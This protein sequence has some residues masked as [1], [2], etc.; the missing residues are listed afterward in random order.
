MNNKKTIL[1]A[2]LLA[3]GMCSFKVQA[4]DAPIPPALP[5]ITPA[6]SPNQATL[7]ADINFRSPL[8]SSQKNNIFQIYFRLENNFSKSEAGI[9]YGVQLVK[10]NK[11]VDEKIYTNDTLSVENNNSIQKIFTYTAPDYLSGN[12]DLWLVA[13]NE[14]GLP[15]AAFKLKDPITLNGNG[16]Y[17][18]INQDSCAL[19]IDGEAA[20]KKYTLIQGVSLNAN[21]NLKLSCDA[22]SHFKEPKTISITQTAF[23][24]SAFGEQIGQPQKETPITFQPQEKKTVIIAIKKPNDPQAYDTLINFYNSDQIDQAKIAQSIDVHYV[25]AGETATIQKF[26]LDKIG[27]QK[28]NMIEA[29]LRWSGSADNFDGSR[30][31]KTAQKKVLADIDIINQTNQVCAQVKDQALDQTANTAKFTLKSGIDCTD[32]NVKVT[33][34]NEQGKVLAERD[35]R[36]QKDKII[37]GKTQTSSQ[38]NAKKIALLI[39]CIILLFLVIAIIAKIF[40]SSKKSGTKKIISILFFLWFLLGCGRNVA[41]AATFAANPGW[42]SFDYSINF[43]DNSTNTY[44]SGATVNYALTGVYHETCNNVTNWTIFSVD[45]AGGSNYLQLFYANVSSNVS[46]N[47]SCTALSTPGQ[48]YVNF[49]SELFGEC[50]SDGRYDYKGTATSCDGYPSTSNIDCYGQVGCVSKGKN[51]IYHTFAYDGTSCNPVEESG[52]EIITGT[53]GYNSIT[54]PSGVSSG[55]I[56][57]NY[58]PC[59]YGEVCNYCISSGYTSYASCDPTYELYTRAGNYVDARASYYYT[60]SAPP[61]ATCNISFGSSSYNVNDWGP[62]TWTSSNATG[63]TL[64]C[65]ISGGSSAIANGVVA[66]TSTGYTGGVYG[67]QLNSAGTV[68]CTLTPYNGSKAGTSCYA[69]A[70]VCASGYSW[71][72]TTNSCVATCTV[73]SWTPDPSTVCSGTSFT[74]TSNCSTTQTA[75]GTKTDTCQTSGTDVHA[76][77]SSSTSLTGT[78]L[79][80]LRTI[81]DQSCCDNTKSCFGCATGYTWSSTTNSCVPNST[82]SCT[83]SFVPTSLTAPGTASLTWSSTNATV[84]Y[85]YCTGPLPITYGNYGLSYTAGYPFSFTA[86]ETGTETCTFTPYNGLTQGTDCSA[87]VTVT[88]SQFSCTGT[89]PTGATECPNT[90]SGLTANTAW[91][92]VASASACS[93]TTRCQYY[94][95]GSVVGCGANCSGGNT[96]QSGLSCMPLGNFCLALCG[97]GPVRVYSDFS[98]NCSSYNASCGD[99]CTTSYDCAGVTNAICYNTN[100]HEDNSYI[101]NNSYYEPKYLEQYGVYPTG[102]CRNGDY[103]ESTDCNPPQCNDLCNT[104]FGIYVSKGC[105]EYDPSK[106]DRICTREN[107]SNLPQDD[108]FNYVGKCRL[109][110]NTASETC[111]NSLAT[112]NCGG[113]VPSG[114]YKCPGTQE[115]GLTTAKDWKEVT[116]CSTSGSCE[117]IACPTAGLCS[118]ATLSCDGNCGTIKQACISTA[119]TGSGCANNCTASS[120]TGSLYCPC[121]S[122]KWQEVAPN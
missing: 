6:P 111:T 22:T 60:T 1:F 48:H 62:L 11:L 57:F 80:Q 23:F 5:K 10:D 86:S 14:S 98:C 87:T 32:P 54:C 47:G 70:E 119:P 89:L 13:K 34:K 74:Q 65:A 59:S 45:C 38:N 30:T 43:T 51:C 118:P 93:S 117:Y 9:R 33:L 52:G 112:I 85:G 37:E 120:C 115:T 94:T 2:L 121:N 90:Q 105:N 63:A 81:T 7:I 75:T 24:R 42:S 44:S 20:D 99:T 106:T 39:F 64:Y 82:P 116:S 58:N 77:L 46:A 35:F 91:T 79:G 21:E 76:C 50:A 27:Y 102:V 67:V 83:A 96:C 104:V 28:G 49:R 109:S 92:Q 95:S 36:F 31:E 73:S 122:G 40:F 18:E 110:S 114:Y 113:S 100:W 107:V 26:D 56:C 17:L 16:E 72:S 3:L 103:P 4:A 69:T 29:S 97:S 66:T 12:F 15:L 101:Y 8:I 19:R 41:N 108:I 25:I 71:N 55:K 68:T 53:Y 84:T 61:T 78:A 88:A